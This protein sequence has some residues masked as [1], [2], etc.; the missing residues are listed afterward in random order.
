MLHGVSLLRDGGRAPGAAPSLETLLGSRATTRKQQTAGTHRVCSLEETGARIE[1]A[2]VTAG[3]TRV[4]DI[5]GLDTVGIPVFTAMRPGAE[6]GTI[7][8][9]SGKGLTPLAS[10]LSAMCEAVERHAGE[11]QGR[12][13]PRAS[14]RE[15][16]RRTR[17]RAT[18]VLEP[19]SLIL[20]ARSAYHEELALEWWPARDL[21]TGAETLVPAEAVLC[22]YA[23]GAALFGAS[24][25]GLASGNCVPEALLHALLEVLERDAVAFGETLFRGRLL[26]PFS[27]DGAAA[28]LV[29][30]FCAAGIQVYV[31]VFSSDVDLPVFHVLI[32]D[33]ERRDP[34]LIN[35]GF[36]CHLDPQVAL[37]RA[38][39]EAALS[40][41]TVI[42]GGRED[43]DEHEIKRQVGY[44]AFKASHARWFETA[45]EPR[46]ALGELPDRS[47][48]SVR[49]DLDVVLAALAS[50]GLPR[51]YAAELTVP[52]V[53]FPVVRAIVPGAELHHIQPTRL[54]DR[55]RRAMR[56]E[57]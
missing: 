23:P 8:V 40:R 1:A 39:T 22:P 5:T 25:N 28:E 52:E 43:L 36:G 45:R 38:L 18:R 32:D 30:R 9:Y 2:A 37:V 35:G 57:A 47:T 20:D 13:G 19:T 50:S 7:T 41:A 12:R 48:D 15:L 3:V 29:A 31:R 33:V 54:G 56:A 27:L 24:S 4:A 44:E 55:L 16:R 46:I 14:Y 21:H 6:P 42:A 17:G 49:G 10:R 26:D 11:R 51:A 53:G 34:M